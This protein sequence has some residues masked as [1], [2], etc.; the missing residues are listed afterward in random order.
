MPLS[1]YLGSAIKLHY[2]T[3]SQLIPK[4]R[5]ANGRNFSR[6]SNSVANRR[7]LN[8]IGRPSLCVRFTR[9]SQRQFATVQVGLNRCHLPFCPFYSSDAEKR[10]QGCRIAKTSG[11]SSPSP[12]AAL[13]AHGIPSSRIFRIL[14]Q[15]QRDDWIVSTTGPVNFIPPSGRHRAPVKA[16]MISQSFAS[17]HLGRQW[18][19]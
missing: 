14:G 4:R 18:H 16:D 5:Q 13:D 9:A 2:Q 3:R 8:S 7:Q 1:V 19:P 15:H 10:S 6:L 17:P 11:C 12:F